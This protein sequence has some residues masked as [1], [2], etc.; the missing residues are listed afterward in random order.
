MAFFDF[1]GYKVYY[2]VHGES[3]EPLLI[4]NGIMMSTNSSLLT[5]SS[6]KE[7]LFEEI[8]FK[9]DDKLILCEELQK[10]F[11]KHNII[12]NNNKITLRNR[13]ARQE[14]TGIIVNKFPN[15]KREYYKQLRAI[16]YNCIAMG[17]YNTAKKYIDLGLC[18]NSK[19][20]SCKDK[21]ES[22]ELIVNWFKMVIK[23][24]I[25]FIKQVKGEAH[26]S[27]YALASKANEVFKEDLFDLIYYLICHLIFQNLF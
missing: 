2:E 20:I 26:P 21:P 19:I 4:L 22:E 3:G 27:F 11:K 14:I 6:Y 1:E 25:N 24:K 16:L 23:G 18:N 7:C 13:F 10:I 9:V 5:F 17:V 12:V 8:V 15:V